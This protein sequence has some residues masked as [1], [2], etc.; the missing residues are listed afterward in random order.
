MGIAVKVYY[1]DKI[2][3]YPCRFVG[4]RHRFRNSLLRW[5]DCSPVLFARCRMACL[6]VK[7]DAEPVQVSVGVYDSAYE[8][9]RAAESFSP[10]KWQEPAKDS[11]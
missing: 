8:G 2:S 1:S 6:F 10:P 11:R 5:V 4:L 3:P 7:Q 9:Q